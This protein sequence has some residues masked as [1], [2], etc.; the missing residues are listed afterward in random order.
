MPLVA[1]PRPG[2]VL[3][4]KDRDLPFSFFPVTRGT[5]RYGLHDAIFAGSPW[6]VMRGAIARDVT[7]PE[8]R[9]EALAFL[10]QAE[11]FYGAATTRVSANPLLLYYAFLNLGKALVRVRGFGGSL[12]QAVHGLSERMRAGGRNELAD[13]ELVVPQPFNNR[14]SVFSELI[15]RLGFAAPANGTVY[16]VVHLLPQIVVGHRL[17]RNASRTHKERFVALDEINFMVNEAQKQIWLRMHL[18]RG[19]LSRYDIT[20]KRLLDETQ[21]TGKFHE[22]QAARPDEVCLESINAV[23]YAGRP[24]DDVMQL[25]DAIRPDLWQLVTTAPRSLYRRYYLYLIPQSEATARLPQIA[26]LWALF[27]YFGSIVRYRPH[28]FDRLLTSEYGP[29]I[30][31]FVSS[32]SE[33]LLYL[34]ASEMERRVI[35]RPAIV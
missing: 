7:H 13:S 25:V 31:E 1:Q 26:S 24:T 5:R 2:A 22:V 33:Q 16:S 10:E 14:T 3:Q 29:F 20:R 11:D 34:L 35:A 6:A 9:A 18:Q 8:Q 23:T 4:V 19:D 28:L 12:D 30:S 21:L 17:W 27:Y 32:Q 15:V